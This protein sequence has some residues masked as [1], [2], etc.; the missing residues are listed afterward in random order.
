[1]DLKL[2]VIKN[3]RNNQLTFSLPKKKFKKEFLKNLERKKYLRLN[4]KDTIK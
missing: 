2:K 4:I 3:K 1:M